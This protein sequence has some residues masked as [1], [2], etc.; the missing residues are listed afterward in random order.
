MFI[1]EHIFKSIYQE[2]YLPVCR[3]LNYYTSE[4]YI[5]EEIVQEVFVKL[6]ED[7]DTL[8]INH[9][10][11]YVYTA[12]RNRLFNYYRNQQLH[13]ARIKEWSEFEVLHSN[14]TDC[15]DRVEFDQLLYT[16]MS[17]LSPRCKEVFMMSKMEKLSYKEIASILNLSEKTVENQMGTALKNIRSFLRTHSSSLLRLFI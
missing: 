3:Y 4:K 5:I 7:R 8:E 11:T 1:D 17:E 12:T 2:Y 10:K 13:E 6:W 9:I 14:T 16:A 15:V